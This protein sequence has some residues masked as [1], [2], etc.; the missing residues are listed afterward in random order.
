MR[1]TRLRLRSMK[2]CVNSES[3][4]QILPFVSSNSAMITL[5]KQLIQNNNQTEV[6]STSRHRK[7]IIMCQTNVK[8]A[9][10]S[11]LISDRSQD[12][13]DKSTVLKDESRYLKKLIDFQM[14]EDQKKRRDIL[15]EK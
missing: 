5:R 10:S 15:D 4:K 7:V 8:V 2:K 13:S 14:A 6:R 11:P 3:L 1:E 12:S 9:D